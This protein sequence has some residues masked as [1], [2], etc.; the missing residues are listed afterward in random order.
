L[1]QADAQQPCHS[2]N[3]NNFTLP[4]HNA[5]LASSK[6]TIPPTKGGGIP[7][8]KGG[9]KAPSKSKKGRKVQ[10][11]L[12]PEGR[13]EQK[14]LKALSNKFWADE[15]KR[16]KKEADNKVFSHNGEKK[17]KVE[18]GPREEDVERHLLVPD[19]NSVVVDPS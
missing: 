13:E 6:S 2:N 11:P 5:G 15:R 12:T 14:V 16:R 8:T 17:V 3:I 18:F 4:I 9:G 19:P 10:E 7:P 1:S